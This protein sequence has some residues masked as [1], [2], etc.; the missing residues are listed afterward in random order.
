MLT[1]LGIA[2]PSSSLL[3]AALGRHRVR[4]IG[5]TW[6]Q[7]EAGT[8]GRFDLTDESGAFFV[9]DKGERLA[10]PFQSITSLEY[11]QKSG[12]RIG[13]TIGWGMAVG[14]WMLPMLLSK[15]R[16]HYLSIGFTGADAKAQGVVLE[17]GKDITRATL[18][19]LEVRSGRKIEFETTDARNNVG[20]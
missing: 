10:I 12:R 19:T 16:K 6:T 18:K 5:G 2:L 8:P 7:L 17:L 14:A 1:C 15:K 3:A 4:Y 9:M 11:G 13:A 20:N